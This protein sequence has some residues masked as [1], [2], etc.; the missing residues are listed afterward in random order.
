ML[1]LPKSFAAESTVDALGGVKIGQKLE[2]SNGWGRVQTPS[3][4]VWGK[5]VTVYGERGLLHAQTCGGNVIDL[6][7]L[8]P[9]VQPNEAFPR[10]YNSV[11]RYPFTETE[12]KTVANKILTRMHDEGWRDL[13]TGDPYDFELIRG[14]LKRRVNWARPAKGTNYV[15]IVIGDGSQ[16]KCD[17]PS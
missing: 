14:K 4:W 15:T 9:F 17:S 1:I 16:K 8:I 13:P 10:L 3:T 7:F 12:S 11:A 6:Y 2:P 5:A